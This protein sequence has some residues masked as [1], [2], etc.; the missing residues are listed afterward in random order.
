[1]NKK[2]DVDKN[3][4]YFIDLDLQISKVI[5]WG[6]DDRQNLKTVEFQNPFQHRVFISKGQYNKLISKSQ[7]ILR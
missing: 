7:T 1:M 4:R 3:T 2:T 6:Y 5:D